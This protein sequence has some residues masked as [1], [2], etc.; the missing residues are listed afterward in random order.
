[1][2]IISS[3][4]LSIVCVVLFIFLSNELVCCYDFEIGNRQDS[5]NSIFIVWT[6]NLVFILFYFLYNSKVDKLYY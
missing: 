2:I 6:Y 4:K 5:F 3:L 1:M